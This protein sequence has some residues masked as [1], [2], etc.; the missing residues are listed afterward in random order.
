[1][2]V[3]DFLVFIAQAIEF[4]SFLF[5]FNDALENDFFMNSG[6]I[7]LK[8]CGYDGINYQSFEVARKCFSWEIHIIP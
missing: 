6:F 2:I 4:L 7:V 3:F 8:S 5:I 1:V